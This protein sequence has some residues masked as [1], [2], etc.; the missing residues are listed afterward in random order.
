M[1]ARNDWRHGRDICCRQLVVLICSVNPFTVVRSLIRL[2]RTQDDIAE[3]GRARGIATV[4]STPFRHLVPRLPRCYPAI[5]RPSP[6]I[7]LFGDSPCAAAFFCR[8]GF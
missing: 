2:R 5:G 7:S 6:H 1:L 8:L 4:R 3:K